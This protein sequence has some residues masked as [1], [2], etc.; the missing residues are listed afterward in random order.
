LSKKKTK[1]TEHTLTLTVSPPSMFADP[2]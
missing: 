1:F 2:S